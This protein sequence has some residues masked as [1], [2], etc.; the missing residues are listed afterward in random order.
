MKSERLFA[1]MQLAEME[2]NSFKTEASAEKL[3]LAKL[4]YENALKAEKAATVVQTTPKKVVETTSKKVV[5][6]APK[7]VVAKAPVEEEKQDKSES[8]GSDD[9]ETSETEGGESTEEEEKKTD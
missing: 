3:E 8:E 9:E 6:P 2:N 1:D 5:E 4:A 7:K